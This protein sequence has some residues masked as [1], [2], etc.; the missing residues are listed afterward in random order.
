MPTRTATYEEDFYSWTRHQAAALRRAAASRVNLPDPL[1]FENL[2]EEIESLGISQLRELHSRYLAL[3]VH[4]L[5]W[6]H[7]PEKRTG[8]CRSTVRTQRHELARLMELSP[9]LKPKRRRELAAAYE[10]ARENA[11]DEIGL[12]ID[13]FPA[14]CPYA[15]EEVTSDEFWPG[16]PWA[17]P[18]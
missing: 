18:R 8:S 16:E 17:R 14:A 4:L 15:L 10:R 7:Q 6:Q 1:D 9:G 13:L 3:L 12:P 11:A 2:A 5:K